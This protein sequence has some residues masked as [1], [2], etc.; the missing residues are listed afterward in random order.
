MGSSGERIGDIVIFQDLTATKHMEKEVEKSKNLALIGEVAAGLAHEIRNPLTALSGSIQLLKRN[1]DLDKTDT[2]LMEIVLRGR[3]QLENLISNFLLL[4]RPM[5]ADRED[6]DANDIVKDI[7]ESLRYSQDWH[8]NTRMEMDFCDRA[9]MFGNRTEVKQ[10]L[11]NLV[12]N[13]VQAMEDG[14]TLKIET[15]VTLSDNGEEFLV[16][17]IM[18]TG[19]GIE[20][21]KESKVFTPFFTTKERGTGLGL[22]IA[23][24][25][26]ESHG[27]ELKIESRVGEGTTCRIS[28]PQNNSLPRNSTKT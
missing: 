26:V 27:G 1:L 12:L 8:E 24:R 10:M 21:D 19:C 23:N 20:E 15:R 9:Y 17:S 11:W 28:F 7:V 22:A 3:E 14:G 4:A 18:D 6:I 5:V 2:R 25:I 13:A 16:V